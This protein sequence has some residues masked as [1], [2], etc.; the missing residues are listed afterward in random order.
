MSGDI[1]ESFND[2]AHLAIEGS[3]FILPTDPQTLYLLHITKTYPPSSF[4]I[5]LNA[6]HLQE[7]IQSLP[8]ISHFDIGFTTLLIKFSQPI[9]SIPFDFVRIFCQHGVIILLG[10]HI[11]GY[12]KYKYMGNSNDSDEGSG[13]NKLPFQTRDDDY[14]PL[15]EQDEFSKSLKCSMK[16]RLIGFI[17][18]SAI[19]WF[20]SI[21]GVL[22]LVIKHDVTQ[23]AIMY[24]LGQVL[25]ITGYFFLNN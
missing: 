5:R 3:I 11:I 9:E 8:R 6:L 1:E 20:L 24:S 13:K 23:F 21:L 15:G 19:G 4:L 17:A 22:V 16:T 7:L 10:P 2:L 14:S 25:N 12:Y 18:C